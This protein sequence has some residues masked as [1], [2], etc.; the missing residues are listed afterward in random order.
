MF[1]LS[2][3]LVLNG[4]ISRNFYREKINGKMI[5]KMK[6]RQKMT[7]IK[8]NTTQWRQKMLKMKMK[9]S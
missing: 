7:I 6:K 8:K 4:L 5:V 2:C 9:V 1:S 3:F